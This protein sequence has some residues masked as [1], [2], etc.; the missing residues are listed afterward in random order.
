MGALDMFSVPRDVLIGG[1]REHPAWEGGEAH[2][3]SVSHVWGGHRSAPEDLLCAR[4]SE[5]WNRY[6]NHP[7]FSHGV[8][9]GVPGMKSMSVYVMSSLYLSTSQYFFFETR[10]KTCHFHWLRRREFDRFITGEPAENQYKCTNAVMEHD[11]KLDMTM[12]YVFW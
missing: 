4:C 2:Q 10:Q 8:W 12:F 3:W 7:C 5:I 1:E 11:H 9:F 6:M